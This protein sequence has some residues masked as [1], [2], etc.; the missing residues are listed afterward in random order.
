MVKNHTL[1]PSGHCRIKVINPLLTTLIAYGIPIAILSTP[2]LNSMEAE[3]KN[4]ASA[5]FIGD[6]SL[7]TIGLIGAVLLSGIA[8]AHEKHSHP[9]LCMIHACGL[10]GII[11]AGFTAFSA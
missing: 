6:V 11:L 3:V 10:P 9:I 5:P 2:L 7:T 4:V 1:C 8:T